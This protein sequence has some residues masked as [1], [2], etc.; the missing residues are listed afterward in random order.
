MDA[1]KFIR[2]YKRMCVS[3]QFCTDCPLHG[4]QGLCVGVPA[5]YT[6][7]FASKV[8]K[9]V[10]DWSAAHPV[11][12]RADLFKKAYPKAGTDPE[13]VLVICPKNVDNTIP[14]PAGAHCWKCRQEYWNKEV[15]NGR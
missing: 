4:N 11:T 1:N 2:E 14:C 6:E 3:F 12:T 15:Q 9:C 8:E 13:G 10:E 7:E 5:K